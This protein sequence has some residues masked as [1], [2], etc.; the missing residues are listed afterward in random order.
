MSEDYQRDTGLYQGYHARCSPKKAVEERDEG[1]GA[2]MIVL[3][4]VDEDSRIQEFALRPLIIRTI[5]RKGK[6][7]EALHIEKHEAVCDLCGS[8]IA[9]TRK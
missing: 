1:D 9:L 6:I 8:L 5:D 2:R 7:K 4:P 3:A